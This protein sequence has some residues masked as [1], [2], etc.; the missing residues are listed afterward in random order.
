MKKILFAVLFTAAMVASCLKPYNPTLGEPGKLSDITFTPLNGACNIHYTIP[1]DPGF[2]YAKAVYQLDNGTEIIKSSSKYMNTIY[3]DGF[4]EEKEYPVALYTVNDKDEEVLSEVI[5]VKPLRSS[6][7]DVVESITLNSGVNSAYINVKNSSKQKTTVYML[8]DDG[9]TEILKAYVSQLAEENFVVTPLEEKEYSISV[10]TSDMYGNKSK[11]IDLGKVTPLSDIF[12]HKKRWK[13]LEDQF[14]PDE[15]IEKTNANYPKNAA[16]AFWDGEIESLWDGIIDDGTTTSYFN[17][18][19][20]APYNYYLD[21]GRSVQISRVKTWQRRNNVATYSDWQIQE[22]ELYGS[23][24]TDE[25]GVAINW[26][27]LNSFRIIKPDTEQEAAKEVEEGHEFF[28]DS[29]T[30]NF[31]KPLRY[32]RMRVT[33]QFGIGVGQ[34]FC[35]EL[36]LYGLD[37]DTE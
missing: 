2:V 16:M 21:L 35:S 3:V 14:V 23:N 17:S 10:Y 37:S 22:Y 24:E 18:G 11:T 32:L 12:L 20:D 8:I 28:V 33:S 1:D 4:L 15:L 34:G 31:S 27:K 9:E 19:S 25:N 26:F 7:Y 36:N 13:I 29:K 6:I 5:N 30:Y